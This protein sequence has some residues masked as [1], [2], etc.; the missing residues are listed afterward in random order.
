MSKINL[1]DYYPD[2]YNE[3]YIIDAPDEVMEVMQEAKRKE[4][5][6]QRKRYRYKAHYSLDCGDGIEHD[7]L[8]YA[9]T[10]EETCEQLERQREIEAA[11]E[12]LPDKQARRIRAHYYLGISVS[13]IAKMEGVARSRVDE[14]IRRGL[15]NLFIFLKKT[16]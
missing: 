1:R 4:A 12:L 11:I 2:F 10:P 16:E 15:H 14:S 7:A 6:Y 5:S 13:D 3:D 9:P 8:L